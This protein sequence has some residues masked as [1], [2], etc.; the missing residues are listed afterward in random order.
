MGNI[1]KFS[2]IF[3]RILIAQIISDFLIEKISRIK[4]VLVFYFLLI[5]LFLP[6]L[7]S[8]L[9]WWYIIFLSLIFLF[10]E[11]FKDQYI[12]KGFDRGAVFIFSEIIFLFFA[13]LVSYYGSIFLRTISI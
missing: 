3:T 12:K 10:L 1:G 9:M 5:I 8:G 6:F 4:R 7:H 2:F 11:N 13:S